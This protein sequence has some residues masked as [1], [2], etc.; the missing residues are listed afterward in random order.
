[1][2]SRESTYV[3]TSRYQGEC[4]HMLS[5]YGARGDEYHILSPGCIEVSWIGTQ[6]RQIYGKK[7]TSQ[8]CCEQF[9]I[10]MILV[11]ILTHI[12]SS[13]LS[14][15]LK[16][17]YVSYRQLKPSSIKASVWTRTLL[18]RFSSHCRMAG[19]FRSWD[20]SGICR[21]EPPYRRNIQVFWR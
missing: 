18:R 13:I 4:T 5:I 16:T 21:L 12:A 8:H 11:I 20:T 17:N 10:P 19:W 9:S 3:S 1:M 7:H 15:R 2:H 14:L 6:Q